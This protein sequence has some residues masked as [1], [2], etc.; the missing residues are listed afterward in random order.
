MA[1]RFLFPRPCPSLAKAASLGATSTLRADQIDVPSY[2]QE[3]SG[4][5]DFA[6][7]AIGR[8]STIESM[9][10]MLAAGGTAVLV[11]M[12]A[13]GSRASIDPF[14]LADQGKSILGCNYGSSVAKIKIPKLAN[15]YP[16][17]RAAV[18]W[19]HRPDPALD[20]AAAGLEDLRLGKGLR[21]ILIP[22]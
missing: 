12:T 19:A 4:G 2:L 9:P 7:E 11:G 17:R 13:A 14:D 6:F 18:G 20:E 3:H 15:L 21:L 1:G 10:S 5:V 22:S 8:V 16:R